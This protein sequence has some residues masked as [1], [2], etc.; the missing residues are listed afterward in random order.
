[1]C[2][3]VGTNGDFKL[4][5]YVIETLAAVLL[6]MLPALRFPSAAEDMFGITGATAVCTVCYVI[7]VFIHYA[8]K[9]TQALQAAVPHDP[10]ESESYGETEPLVN[11]VKKSWNISFYFPLMAACFGVVLSAYSLYATIVSF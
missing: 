2:P 6:S 3:Q 4:S 11:K 1:M 9:H 10:V 7:P 8:F 5:R